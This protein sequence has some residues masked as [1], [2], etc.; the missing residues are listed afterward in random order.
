MCSLVIASCRFIVLDA[1]GITVWRGD[2]LLLDAVDIRLAPGEVVQ[3]QGD[4]GSGKTT[5]LRILA[6]LSEADE[7]EVLWAG[8]RLRQNRVDFNQSLLYLGHKPGISQGLTPVE[9]LALVCGLDGSD[10]ARIPAV[11]E[12]LGLGERLE[13]KASALSAGQKRRVGLARLK[14]QAR[15]LWILDEPLTA[16][17]AHGVQWV[18]SCIEAH[19][20]AGGMVLFTTHQPLELSARSVRTVRLEANA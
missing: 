11:L 1:Q 12:E 15:P 13:L 17:D 16:I 10:T 2:T 3:L 5:L 14:L 19:S 18:R 8:K 4:N 6:G 7:G 20:H 9:N